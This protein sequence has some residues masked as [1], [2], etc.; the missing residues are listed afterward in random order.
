[1]NKK[2]IKDN[3]LKAVKQA[4]LQEAIQG[5]LTADWRKENPEPVEGASELF[6]RIKAEKALRQAQGK[7]KKGKP[8][9]PISDDE[10]PF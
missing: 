8:L 3:L 4:I 5:K 7:I 9:P 10:I 2:K 1:M 6:E